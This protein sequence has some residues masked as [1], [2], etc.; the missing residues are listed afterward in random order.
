MQP[1]ELLTADL[2]AVGR[3]IASRTANTEA[4]AIAQSSAPQLRYDAVVFNLLRDPAQRDVFTRSEQAAL[5][6]RLDQ[7][8]RQLAAWRAW[9][10]L[11]GDKPSLDDLEAW[12]ADGGCEAVDGCWVESD[13]HCEHGTPSWLLVMGLV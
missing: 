7:Q 5:I 3:F 6:Q 13:G 8:T 4:A 2:A 11:H 12:E 10:M 1:E 9:G